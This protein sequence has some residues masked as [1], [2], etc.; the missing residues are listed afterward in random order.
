MAMSIDNVPQIRHPLLL[1][2]I[3]FRVSLYLDAEDVL[4]CSH[5]SKAFQAAFAP[6]PYQL[7]FGKYCTM[8]ESLLI[9]GPPLDRLFDTTYWDS[10]KALVRQNSARLQSLTMIHWNKSC[11]G[12]KMPKWIPL[13]ECAQFKNL[14]SLSVKGGSIDKERRALYWRVFENLESLTLES[15]YVAPPPSITNVKTSESN[16]PATRFPN[17]RKLALNCLVGTD[18][19]RQLEWFICV[20]PILQTLEWTLRSTT[21]LPVQFVHRFVEMTWPQLDSITIKGDLNEDAQDNYIPILQAAQQPFKVLE[22]NVQLLLPSVFVLLRQSHFKTLLKVDLSLATATP[23]LGMVYLESVA[24]WV[25]EVLESCPLLEHLTAN[26]I[27]A[28]DIINGK[29]WV[30]LGLKELKVIIDMGFGR[31]RR[32][33]GLK[34]PKITESEQSLCSAVF[35]QLGRLDQL[36]VLDLRCH[37][38]PVEMEDYFP[39]PLELRLGLG[40]LSRLKDIEVIGFHGS[41]DIRMTDVEWMLQQWPYLTE[42]YGSQLS[43]KP[44]RTFE[45]EYVRNYL[46]SS[47]LSSRGVRF[48]RCEGDM[49]VELSMEMYVSKLYDTESES[50]SERL[51]ESENEGLTED[52]SENESAWESEWESEGWETEKESE[53]ED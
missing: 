23:H 14:H 9:K 2:E 6:S 47:M 10:C 42:I 21:S 27:S 38:W 36:R 1:P 3:L 45:Y 34:R 44:S 31:T 19:V 8:I 25:Q 30:C 13:S 50:G 39:L 17:L 24:E 16:L 51:S 52:A 49:D 32:D 48:R 11:S 5:V 20:C 26:V 28:H 12:Q 33:R 46:L 53:L 22:I 7:M 35:E 4:A 43:S 15:I 29:P 41:Q 37:Y 18:P 40:Q